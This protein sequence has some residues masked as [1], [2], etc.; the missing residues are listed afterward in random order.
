[1]LLIWLFCWLLEVICAEVGLDKL[2]GVSNDIDVKFCVAAAVVSLLLLLYPLNLSTKLSI[3]DL[4]TPPL[5]LLLLLLSNVPDIDRFRLTRLFWLIN[6]GE[7][8]VDENGDDDAPIEQPLLILLLLATTCD[9][10]DNGLL[11]WN[12]VSLLFFWCWCFVFYKY[13]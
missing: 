8:E 12:D 2:I 4:A 5:P 1:M 3:D 6:V 11:L 13:Q 7:V 9:D 10:V